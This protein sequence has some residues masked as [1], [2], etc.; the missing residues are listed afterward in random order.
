MKPIRIVLLSSAA[1]GCLVC[2]IAL[3]YF[4]KATHGSGSAKT[5]IASASKPT[6]AWF[7]KLENKAKAAKKFAVRRNFNSNICFL[8]D[9]NLPSGSNRFFVYDLSKD[10]ITDAAL[11]A[12]GSCNEAWLQ[13]RKYSNEVGSGCTSPGRYKVGKP[14]MGNFG[15]AYKLYGLDSTNSNAYARYVVLHSYT[16]V[17]DNEV[18]PYPICQSA[19]CPMVSN[20]FMKKLEEIIDKSSRPIL[21]WIYE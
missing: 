7:L 4:Y 15:R 19:G 21:L 13:G 16:C 14:Y 6:P 3:G 20:N 17:P 11:V 1:I 9:M 12:H 2:F 10:S 18:D 8:V 5:L